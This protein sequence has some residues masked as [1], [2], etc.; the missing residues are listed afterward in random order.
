MP[1]Q[2]SGTVHKANLEDRRVLVVDDNPN[3]RRVLLQM[4]RDFGMI[5]DEARSGT[6]A[7][8]R[9]LEAHRQG[10]PYDVAF[11]DMMMAGIDGI[12][13][14]KRLH[15]LV[16]SRP[17]LIAVSGFMNVPLH[18]PAK[19]AGA[20]RVLQKPLHPT[21]LLETI[22]E[23]VGG[24]GDLAESTCFGDAPKPK[25][26]NG[27]SILLAE[28]NVL[29]Q[30]VAAAFL[31][32]WGCKVSLA[33]DG[34]QALHLVQE[35]SYD[36]VLM[37]MQMPQM[38]GLEATRAI[39][40]VERLA[41]LPIVAM[42]ANA[43]PRDRERCLEAGMNE[44]IAKPIDPERLLKTILHMLSLELPSED[45]QP[46][47]PDQKSG[48]DIEIEG[49][50]TRSG[51]RRVLQNAELYQSMLRRFVEHA[52]EFA[53][54]SER[55][56][57]EQDWPVLERLAHTLKSTALLIGADEVGQVAVSLE[58]AT[59]ENAAGDQIE[60]L[61]ASARQAL[62]KAAAAIGAWL[63]QHRV[64]T[65]EIEPHGGGSAQLVL[66]L[67]EC[68]LHDDARTLRFCRDH[69]AA[70]AAV[71]GTRFEAIKAAVERFDFVGALRLLDQQQ[72]NLDDVSDGK[73]NERLRTAT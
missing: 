35:N 38:D 25:H 67:R 43:M 22:T 28:D 32:D 51:M 29:N 11:V 18:K 24:A 72:A 12:E 21:V 69:A 45:K 70:F 53:V 65:A 4:F 46:V 5:V 31:E 62:D 30:E 63:D 61:T 6:E 36:L 47:M 27:V 8:E 20:H 14:I 52:A 15:T 64:G 23:L 50:D 16:P 42:T 9:C 3:V 58:A 1:E 57:H 68:L 2:L 56:L 59:H 49:I 41:H 66:E 19:L 40:A 13:V 26:L 33:A 34:A 10:C 37:D 48:P 73:N 55:A 44:H 60:V 71:F 39:R 17:M 54:E 7:I